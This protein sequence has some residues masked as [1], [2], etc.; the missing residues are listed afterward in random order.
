MGAV[1]LVGAVALVLFLTLVG[2][3]NAEDTAEAFMAA[4]QDQDISAIKDYTCPALDAE[5]GGEEV[6]TDPQYAVTDYTVLTVTED[7]DSATADISGTVA[8]EQFDTTLT[9]E[10]NDDG[11]FEVCGFEESSSAG[12]SGG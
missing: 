4:L 1:V 9:L 6:A 8:G 11:D 3:R 7:G 2:N 5:V 12:S 10:K